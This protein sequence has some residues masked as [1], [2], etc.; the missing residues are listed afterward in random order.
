M[1]ATTY[2]TWTT[3]LSTIYADMLSL[4]EQMHNKKLSNATQLVLRKRYLIVLDQWKKANALMVER[5][6]SEEL[7]VQKHIRALRELEDGPVL[8]RV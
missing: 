3:E 2:K 8:H 7:R 4:S 1:D 6:A 5:M